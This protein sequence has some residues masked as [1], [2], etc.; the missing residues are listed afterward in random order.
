M[1]WQQI[2]ILL[3]ITGLYVVFGGVVFYVL[4]SGKENQS[5]L[6]LE[7]RRFLGKCKHYHVIHKSSKIY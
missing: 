6:I 2:L 1:Y 4:E 7:A 5:S 3:L